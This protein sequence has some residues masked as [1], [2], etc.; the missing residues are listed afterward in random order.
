MRKNVVNG[1]W[2]KPDGKEICD[3]TTAGRRE[4]VRRTAAMQE[5]QNNLCA[6]CGKPMYVPCFD[7]ENGRGAGKHDDRI[8]VEGIWQ[9]AALHWTC[10]SERGS[11]R[12]PYVITQ[13]KEKR[14]AGLG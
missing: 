12:T 14:P 8:E 13:P 9:N 11:K 7:H 4:Y 6:H 2:I 5:R 1:V 3:Q 10:N